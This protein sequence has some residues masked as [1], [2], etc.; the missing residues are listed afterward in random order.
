MDIGFEQARCYRCGKETSIFGSEV[1]TF[2]PSHVGG[3]PVRS[4]VKCAECVKITTQKI[5]SDKKV[6]RNDRCSCGSRK[7][8]KKC[9][10]DN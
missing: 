2:Y 6:G 7:K 9:C 8:Y 10:I 5:R 3:S 4:E 1:T